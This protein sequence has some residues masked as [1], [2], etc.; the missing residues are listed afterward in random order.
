MAA[1]GLVV[2]FAAALLGLS[3]LGAGAKAG[4][5]K[6]GRSCGEVLGPQ[7]WPLIE[8]EDAPEYGR[9]KRRQRRYIESLIPE[10]TRDSEHDGEDSHSGLIPQSVAVTQALSV[11]PSGKPLRV[12][13]LPGPSPVYEVKLRVDGQVLRVHVDAQSAQILGQ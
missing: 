8:V 13:L 6:P 5:C 10:E 12:R 9:K 2:L 4:W 11:Y 7:R 1:H 3:A